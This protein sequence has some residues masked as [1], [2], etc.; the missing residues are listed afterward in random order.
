MQRVSTFKVEHRLAKSTAVATGVDFQSQTQTFK[1]K[2]RLSK[3]NTD[4]QKSTQNPVDVL[5]M[6]IRTRA[7]SYAVS[8]TKRVQEALTRRSYSVFQKCVEEK[9]VLISPRDSVF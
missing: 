1:V 8:I 3:A 6:L 2:P 5:A 7:D 9:Y 4:F